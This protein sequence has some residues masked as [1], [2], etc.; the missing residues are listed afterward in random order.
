MGDNL[1]PGVTVSDLPGNDRETEPRTEECAV[2]GR[3][4]HVRT[5]R[6][7]PF[8]CD[9]HDADDLRAKEQ[10][11]EPPSR[12]AERMAEQYPRR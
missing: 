10:H 6:R 2:C 9:D 3:P 1:P 11:Y 7:G 12:L 8:F 5:S 4:V